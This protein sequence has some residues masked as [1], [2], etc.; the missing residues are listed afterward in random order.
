VSG[1]FIKTE[2]NT[3]GSYIWSW[4]GV[5]S[6]AEAWIWSG[7]AG[8]EGSIPSDRGGAGGSGGGFTKVTVCR[9]TNTEINITVGAGGDAGAAGEDSFISQDGIEL[10][11]VSGAA[12][13]TA[14]ADGGYSGSAGHG[15]FDGG[16]GANNA[17]QHTMFGDIPYSDHGGDGGSS[18][19]P[20]HIGY[21]GEP[22]L[23]GTAPQGGG[24]GGHGGQPP[25]GG[26]GGAT[27]GEDAPGRGG[28]GGGG[29]KGKVS[30][31]GHAGEVWI[32]CP[33][34][35]AGGRCCCDSACPA[36]VTRES[37][38]LPETISASFGS[39]SVTDD[40]MPVDEETGEGC[41]DGPQ[42]N[43]RW[44]VSSALAGLL[45]G[46]FA[47]LEQTE[48]G[49]CC[50][51]YRAVGSY[52]PPE[53]GDG[54]TGQRMVSNP[55]PPSGVGAY[56]QKDRYSGNCKSWSEVRCDSSPVPAPSC[57]DFCGI[58]T[59]ISDGTL[60]VPLPIFGTG[61]LLICIAG[62][63]VT[64]RVSIE[65]TIPCRTYSGTNNNNRLQQ[66]TPQS[67]YLP[68]YSP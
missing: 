51:R 34:P 11:R 59:S 39:V 12:A 55:Y 17:I 32:I 54:A 31:K 66:A 67:I 48:V 49:G 20:N 30:G 13:C 41:V 63:T 44:S 47:F 33:V 7:G 50:F 58:F 62:D 16:R 43:Y 42:S 28:G 26:G 22:T 21:D 3:A 24:A 46:D 40:G 9:G 36:C 19:G 1:P 15:D 18:A 52:D 14:D 8:G 29:G 35:T 53:C 25:D 61:D 10:A 2:Y 38:G 60:Y 45:N 5:E 23:V 56:V 4:P 57:E 68:F 6:A 65:A 27:D 37:L 64:I